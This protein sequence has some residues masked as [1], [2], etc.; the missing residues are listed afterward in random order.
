M[1][2]VQVELKAGRMQKDIQHG[3][4]CNNG[5]NQTGAKAKWLIYFGAS[6]FLGVKA[7]VTA[8]KKCW[9]KEQ[10]VEALL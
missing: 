7:G 3:F 1:L 4:V 9:L 2:K 5:Q 8:Q 6:K 10:K